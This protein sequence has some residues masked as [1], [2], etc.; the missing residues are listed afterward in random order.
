MKGI[1]IDSTGST[2]GGGVITDGVLLI[3]TP[4]SS[5]GANFG[6]PGL[7][8]SNSYNIRVNNCKFETGSDQGNSTGYAIQLTSGSSHN[9]ISNTIAEGASG[10]GRPSSPGIKVDSGCNNNN[11]IGCMT[12]GGGAY[13]DSGSGNNFAYIQS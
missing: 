12:Y 9:L 1:V 13:S 5:S 6:M 10:S 4:Q 3:A 7:L 2:G 8:I 11:F